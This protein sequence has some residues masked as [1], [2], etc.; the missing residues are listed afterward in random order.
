[1]CD[2]NPPLGLHA[3]VEITL[4]IRGNAKP[5]TAECQLIRSIYNS[6]VSGFVVGVRFV[7]LTPSSDSALADFLRE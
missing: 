7:S 5:F 6:R 1:V 3:R 4:T 2:V